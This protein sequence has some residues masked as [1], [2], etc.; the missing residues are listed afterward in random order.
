MTDQTRPDADNE[1]MH[2]LLGAFVLGGLDD[3]DRNAFTAHLR[4][5]AVCQREAA[6]L[7]GMPGLL[8]LVD[9]GTVTLDGVVGA[10]AAPALVPD[11]HAIQ[12][13]GVALP[14][15][16]LAHVRADR[17]RR[18]SRWVAVAAAIAVLA[19][20]LGASVGPVAA[21]INAPPTTHYVATAPAAGGTQVEIDLVTRAWGTQLD[22]RGSGLP[23]SGVLL[24]SV[25]NGAGYTYDIASWSGTPSGRTTL[26]APCWMKPDDITELRVHTR[27]GATLA[28]VS[29][30]TT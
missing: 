18:R 5:C 8:D 23:T 7:S 2:E 4:T 28:T 21:R 9:P 1:R 12:G 6:Q 24:L 3:E 14:L 11:G 30:R 25:T 27:E 29:T 20:G 26:T 13:G 16:L 19:G 17:R 15:P 10:E 22:L